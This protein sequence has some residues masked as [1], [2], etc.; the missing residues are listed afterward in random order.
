MAKI[1]TEECNSIKAELNTYLEQLK[2][3]TAAVKTSIESF[4]DLP[5]D[6]MDGADF[7]K[8]KAHLKSYSKLFESIQLKI[9]DLNIAQRD[10]NDKM[11][12][13]VDEYSTYGVPEITDPV[14]NESMLDLVTQIEQEKHEDY[15]YKKEHEC[16]WEETVV[17]EDD[18]GRVISTSIIHHTACE[19]GVYFHSAEVSAAY[20]IWQKYLKAKKY[21]LRLKDEDSAAYEKFNTA[22]TTLKTDIDTQ[23][24]TIV[25]MTIKASVKNAIVSGNLDLDSVR[26]GA[27]KNGLDYDSGYYDDYNNNTNDG[28]NTETSSN[29]G[30]T[31]SI[32]FSD[33][34]INNTETGVPVFG[35]VVEMWNRLF[36]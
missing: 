28:T 27:V 24:E 16:I 13:Y 32:M 10:A 14:D 19:D 34:T 8:V 3:D 18:K 35:K 25:E 23:N 31:T 22:I 30:S 7:V 11:E 33:N 12:K 9:D 36:G 6:K 15:D 26:A 5:N 20:N 4:C 29:V 21:L 17:N 2:T 1:K